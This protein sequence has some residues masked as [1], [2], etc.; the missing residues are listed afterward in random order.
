MA[1]PIEQELYRELVLSQ[2]NFI[3]RGVIEMDEIY[4]VVKVH[5]H[6]LCDDNYM[7]SHGV[8]QPEWNH[9]VRHALQSLKK[10]TDTIH[11]FGI[12]N[13]WEFT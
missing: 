3:E 9:T 1:R 5:F 11:K 8:N 12:R 4:D 13:F 10:S 6:N 2:L 7:C